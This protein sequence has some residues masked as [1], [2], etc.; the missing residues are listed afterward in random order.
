MVEGELR[1]LVEADLAEL[2]VRALGVVGA[3]V[4]NAAAD[5]AGSGVDRRVEVAGRGMVVTVALLEDFGGKKLV[6]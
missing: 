6:P 3:V 5:A 2:A 4:A 1:V